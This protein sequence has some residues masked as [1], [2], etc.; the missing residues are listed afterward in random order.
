MS[1]T[2]LDGADAILA[3]FS[4]CPPRSVATSF[5]PFP[6]DLKGRLLA[7]SAPGGDGLDT[8]GACTR[9]LAEIY[10]EAVAR[11]LADAGVPA[12]AVEVIG[13][14]GQTVRHRP[15]LGY[16][17]QLNDAARLAERSGIDVVADFRRRDIAAGGQGA[18]LVPVFHHAVFRSE[19]RHRVIVNIGGI[20]NITSLRPDHAISGF[21]CGP[22]N[23]LMD[24][25]TKRHRG[26]EYDKDGR[27]ASEGKVDPELLHRFLEEPFLAKRPPKS[28]GRELFN[29]VWLTDRLDG[30]C[31]PADVQATLL[32]FTAMT[33]V[34]AMDRFCGK[35][36]EIYLCGGG[37]RNRRLAARIGAL[38]LPRP[39]RPTDDLGVPTG[40]V[41]AMAFA[42]L[43]TKCARREEIDLTSITGAAHPCILGA[44]YPA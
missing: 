27:W 30:R 15:D 6:A 18:P 17:I 42:W 2:S 38:A 11:L 1:G 21:D 16:T 43:A 28:T 39:V 31:A 13:C 10:A 19:D 44:L 24:G 5:V 3:D 7:L 22:G 9:Q 4:T 20:G 37:A 29:E 26:E 12:S 34:D 23:V 32:D 40:H 25:W 35:P 36:D 33:I 14:H 8:A 41:E